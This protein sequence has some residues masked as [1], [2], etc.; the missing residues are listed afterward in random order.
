MC[1][2]L[3]RATAI[4]TVHKGAQW[5][6]EWCSREHHSESCAFEEL[7]RESQDTASTSEIYKHTP[8]VFTR[9]HE[10]IYWLVIL[11]NEALTIVVIS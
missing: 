1:S 2:G 9:S 7:E 10:V 5:D 11:R 6:C 8:L 4:A 3:V